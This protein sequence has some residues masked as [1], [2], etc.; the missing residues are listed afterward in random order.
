MHSIASTYVMDPVCLVALVSAAPLATRDTSF[1]FPPPNGFPAITNPSPLL[2]AIEVAAHGTLL[3]GGP[4]SSLVQGDLVSLKFFVFDEILKVTFTSLKN[5]VTN[6]VPDYEFGDDECD[7]I[8]NTLTT[9]TAQEELHEELHT[10]NVNV[11]LKHFAFSSLVQ[12]VVARLH[13]P[14]EPPHRQA[15]AELGSGC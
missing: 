6:S 3:N 14:T 12:T 5:N 1:S 2:A 4:P 7:T 13:Q 9:I 15:T 11:A 8:L 10:L